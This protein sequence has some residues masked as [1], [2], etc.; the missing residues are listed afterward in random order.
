M[1]KHSSSGL[2]L[3]ITLLLVFSITFQGLARATVIVSATTANI[4]KSASTDNQKESGTGVSSVNQAQD[5]RATKPLTRLANRNSLTPLAMAPMFAP[6]I[7]ATL[8]DDIGLGAKKNPGATIT[9]TA[10][11]NDSVADAT[12]VTFT[13]PLDA[14][15][16]QT[17]TV[18][19]RS[20][21]TIVV[22]AMAAN[23]VQ[24]TGPGLAR[25]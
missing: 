14:N 8:A 7:T 4:E 1:F 13:D 10:I 15:T 3:C 11:I 22:A 12:G 18:N 5:A 9:Y 24:D 21:L 16:T 20:F 2:S 19:V 6:T 17:G 25:K 23:S